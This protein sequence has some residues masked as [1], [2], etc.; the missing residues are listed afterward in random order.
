MEVLHCDVST[1][2]QENLG[3]EEPFL[4]RGLWSPLDSAP[5]EKSLA[6]D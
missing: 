6:A 5:M 4:K 2:Y 3:S 1:F